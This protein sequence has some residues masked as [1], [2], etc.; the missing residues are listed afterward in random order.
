VHDGRIDDFV[1]DLR[2]SVAEVSAA[3]STGAH[4]AYGTVE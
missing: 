2:A 3:G 4:G 1:A